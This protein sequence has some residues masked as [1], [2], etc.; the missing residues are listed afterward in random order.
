MNSESPL[1]KLIETLPQQ[2][3]VVWIGLRSERKISLTE[4]LE[5]EALTDSKLKGD[6]YSGRR[7][8]KRQI[9]L[10]QKEHL[11]AV[12]SYMNIEN[13]SP[14]LLRRNIVVKG[15][16][17]LALKNKTFWLGEVLLKYTGECQPCSRME[18][19]LGPGGYNAMLGHG[20]IIARIIKGG[21]IRI[22]DVIKVNSEPFTDIKSSKGVKTKKPRNAGLLE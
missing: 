19:N 17:L 1:Q 11:D 5:A 12:E 7:G 4:V 22:N 13:L 18:E 14:S 2:G 6:H 16:N 15:I 20:G 8:S 9:T 3:K 21:I 10:I